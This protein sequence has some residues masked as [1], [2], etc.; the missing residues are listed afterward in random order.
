MSSCGSPKRIATPPTNMPETPAQ[1][2]KNL[3]QSRPNQW[4]FGYEIEKLS[5]QWG[6]KPSVVMRRARELVH[7]DPCI[8]ASLI[9]Y[10]P[11][12][13]KV[14][15]YKYVAP[16]KECLNCAIN[17]QVGSKN[18]CSVC[19]V[20]AYTPTLFPVERKPDYTKI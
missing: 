13:R 1:K 19:G 11:A 4:V 5:I 2:I 3:L 14:V 20:K 12:R 16:K 10:E 9:Y 18:D 8:E 17:R 15:A 6:E 7:N